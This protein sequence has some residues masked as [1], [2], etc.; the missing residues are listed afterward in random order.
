MSAVFIYYSYKIFE[1]FKL[2]ASQATDVVPSEKSNFV[3]MPRITDVLPS[4]VVASCFI[5]N[6]VRNTYFVI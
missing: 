2:P 1:V 5:M 6:T 3:N 4:V